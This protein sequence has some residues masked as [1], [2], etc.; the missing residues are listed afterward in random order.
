[1]FCGIG[2]IGCWMSLVGCRIGDCVVDVDVVVESVSVVS[3]LLDDSE[4]LCVLCLIM[5]RMFCCSFSVLSLC[6]RS[7]HAASKV[8]KSL[9]CVDVCPVGASLVESAALINTLGLS[10]LS[11]R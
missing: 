4:L 11:N 9:Y 7:V 2:G 3:G 6:S 5:R 8:W 10:P 1:M